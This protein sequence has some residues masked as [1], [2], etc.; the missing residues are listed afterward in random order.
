MAPSPAPAAPRTPPQARGLWRRTPPAI[1]PPVMGLFGLGLAWRA[2][3]PAFGLPG[4][5]AETILGAVTLLYIFCLV[6]WLA[7]PWRRPGVVLEELRVLPGRAGLA[8]MTLSGLL[9]A[10]TLVPYAPRLATAVGATALAAHTALALTI[11]ALILRGPEEA[12]TV[13]PV[14]HL[15]FVGFIL[16]PL[17]ATPLG[18]TGAAQAILFATMPVA[19]AIWTISLWQ[20]FRRIPP[21]PL[22]P[23]LAIHLA[24]ASLF[25]IVASGLGQPWLAAGSALLGAGILAALLVSGRWITA[26]GF[27]PLWGAFT[28][29]LAAF[30]SALLAVSGGAGPLRLAAGL[31]LVAATLIVPPIAVKV[32]QAWA[33]GGLAARTNAA[34]A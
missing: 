14:W 11:T 9:L 2:G 17:A 30:A 26:A 8:A 1:F 31:V 7:K 5:V 13:T 19:A 32:M 15:T 20:L 28:F 3:A 24:P 33:R 10:A 29:P 16:L 23:L 18:Y 27:S 25:A 22:R 4:A 21:A 12:R 34:E 6:A